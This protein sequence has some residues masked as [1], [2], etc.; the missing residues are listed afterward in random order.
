MT[1][2]E[3]LIAIAEWCGFK[4]GIEREIPYRKVWWKDGG[5]FCDCDLPDYLNDLNA[6]HEAEVTVF[7]KKDWHKYTDI[8]CDQVQS[9]NDS[10]IRATAAQRAEALLRTIGKWKDTP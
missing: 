1:P 7:N 6:M 9:K 5:V 10:P 8:L 3:Q 2:E 4:P